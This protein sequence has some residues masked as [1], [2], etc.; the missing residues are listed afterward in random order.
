[1]KNSTL[2]TN[3]NSFKFADEY[4]RMLEYIKMNEELTLEPRAV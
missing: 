4:E 3:K 2:K 1:M